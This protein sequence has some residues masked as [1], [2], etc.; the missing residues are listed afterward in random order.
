MTMINLI[1]G[2]CLEVMTTIDDRCVDCIV[3]SPPYYKKMDYLSGADQIGFEATPQE[4]CQRLAEIYRSAHRVM[5][6]GATMWIV[7]GDTYNNYSPMRSSIA[8]KKNNATFPYQQ[9]KKLVEGYRE[10]ELLG[11]PFM[12]AGAIRESGFVWRS[13][14]IWHKPNCAYDSGSDRPTVSHEYVF[15]FVKAS[16]NGRPYANCD[17]ENGSVWS[18]G[19]EGYGGHPCPF[20]V[21]LAQK[22]IKIASKP[23]DTVMDLM[24]GV[25]SS[26]VA[27]LDSGRRFIGIERDPAFF[28]IAQSRLARHEAE[29][30]E[31]LFYE[32]VA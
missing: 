32:A 8:D 26:G 2:D 14:N 20:P 23:N 11:V 6:E 9:R 10:K 19:T 24:M 21:A 18:I 15:Q 16:G 5:K 25:G 12:L 13:L 22:I 3:T 4:Y 28:S 17:R 31:S 7:I 29:L 1:E 27:A 30:K